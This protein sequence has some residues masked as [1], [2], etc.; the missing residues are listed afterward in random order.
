LASRARPDL[1][2]AAER[3]VGFENSYHDPGAI[4]KGLSNH[5]GS[6]NVVFHGEL[7]NGEKYVAKPHEG[8]AHKPRFDPDADENGQPGQPL[9]DASFQALKADAPDNAKRHD[10]T[11]SIMSAM[12]AHHMVTP[13]MQTNM[14]G[15]HQ[16]SG[17]DPDE[18][19]S[20][21]KRLTMASHHAG[22]LAHVQQFVNDAQTVKGSS[23]EELDNVDAEHRL[24]GVV[25][26]LL[27]GNGDGHGENVMIHKSGHPVLIDHDITLGSAQARGY[28]EHYGKPVLR[29]VFAPGGKLDYQAKL[30][31]DETGQVVPVGTNLPPRMKETLQRIADGYYS[32]TGEGNLGLSDDDHTELKRNAM[33]LLLYGVE[34]T[35]AG[36]HDYDAEERAKKA[37]GVAAPGGST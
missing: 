1:P 4:N 31:K 29:S 20:D 34:G 16:F 3:H 23:K 13:G 6:S 11:Y 26:H 2:S 14:H 7:A 32:P 33:S 10:A 35:L 5:K 30:P 18:G 25:A 22:G 9:D 37:A 8:I 17:Q 19:D 21:S 28:K 27:F 24:H 36:R 12:G 15:R